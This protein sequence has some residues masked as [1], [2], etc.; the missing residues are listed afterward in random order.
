MQILLRDLQ[1]VMVLMHE[2]VLEI[3]EIMVL[4]KFCAHLGKFNFIIHHIN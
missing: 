2:R 1:S 4:Q 3:A